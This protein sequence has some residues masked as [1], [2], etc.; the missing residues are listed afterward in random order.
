MKISIDAPIH[1]AIF[2]LAK[3]HKIEWTAYAV[4]PQTGRNLFHLSDI[5]LPHQINSSGATEIPTAVKDVDGTEFD[6]TLEWRTRDRDIKDP[7]TWRDPSEWN[8]WIHSHNTMAAF[9]SGTDWEEINNMMEERTSPFI[10]IVVNAKREY[11]A[12]VGIPQ[13][14]MLVEAEITRNDPTLSQL[15][16]L[17]EEDRMAMFDHWTQITDATENLEERLTKDYE[18]T[19]P[20]EVTP[21]TSSYG[22]NGYGGYGGYDADD[23]WKSQCQFIH[24]L[25]TSEGADFASDQNMLLFPNECEGWFEC[26]MDGIIV[27]KYEFPFREVDGVRKRGNVILHL[28]DYLTPEGVYAGYKSNPQ[29]IIQ[30][31]DELFP[32]LVDQT[33]GLPV[34]TGLAE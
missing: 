28:D 27:E 17:T 9:W 11:K 2:N 8:V 29:I 4:A 13:L 14:D 23:A 18:L 26:T 22:G 34:A 25:R 16:T 21:P 30:T 20:R 19:K 32:N 5:M 1:E 31:F 3:S 7:A 12:I 33:T 10:C 6:A 24:Q 15:S